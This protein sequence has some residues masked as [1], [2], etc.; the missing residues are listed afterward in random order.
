MSEQQ[1]VRL[2]EFSRTQ[3]TALRR[4]SSNYREPH[5]PS[6]QN[7]KVRSSEG[8]VEE[9][10]V[11]PMTCNVIINV[12]SFISILGEVAVC[13]N[14]QLGTLELLKK[15]C[16]LSCATLLMLRCNNC[17]TNQTFW[18]VCGYFRARVQLGEKNI[19]K[20]NDIMYSSVLGG[21]LVGMGE[22]N[23]RLY[24]ASMNL[25]PPPN[26]GSFQRYKKT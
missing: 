5:S 7:I 2:Y 3:K 21:R 11:L 24:H 8:K 15:S 9:V 16:N 10:D 22:P 19:S 6:K 4:E 25:A 17:L 18:S 26:G 12:E 1:H 14:W 13:R 20:R 23:L